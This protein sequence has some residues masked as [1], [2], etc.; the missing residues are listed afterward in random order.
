MN[1]SWEFMQESRE[2]SMKKSRISRKE[3]EEKFLKESW[4][5]FFFERV[6]QE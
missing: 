2:E 4:K 6:P 1:E 3:S 5:V